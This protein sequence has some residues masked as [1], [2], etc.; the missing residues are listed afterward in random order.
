MMSAGCSTSA[1]RAASIDARA[2]AAAINQA[3][4]EQDAV[5]PKQIPPAICKQKV[6]RVQIV[7]GRVAWH[8]Q[9]DWEQ[10]ADE[11]DSRTTFCHDLLGKALNE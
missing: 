2:T 6:R 3:I 1:R 8:D 7:P 5:K 10:S 11:Q 9:P 4:V